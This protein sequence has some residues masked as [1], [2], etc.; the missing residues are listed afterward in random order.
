MENRELLE[1]E[2]LL[3]MLYGEIGIMIDAH[4]HIDAIITFVDGHIDTYNC[5][6]KGKVMRRSNGR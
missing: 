6:P 1:L 4:S 5:K 2:R 3:R